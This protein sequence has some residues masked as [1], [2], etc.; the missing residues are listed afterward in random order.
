MN[1]DLIKSGKL[2]RSRMWR[3]VIL[4]CSLFWLMVIFMAWGVAQWL[5]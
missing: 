5:S 4:G 3:R 2:L 1:N